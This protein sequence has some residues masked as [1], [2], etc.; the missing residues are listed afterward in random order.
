MESKQSVHTLEPWL[1]M[2][3]RDELL[4]KQSKIDC[5]VVLE[6]PGHD[7]TTFCVQS[8]MVTDSLMVEL[9]NY[10]SREVEYI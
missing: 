4:A 10:P 2:L 6:L 3:G 7:L 9:L 5:K 8:Q 1:H